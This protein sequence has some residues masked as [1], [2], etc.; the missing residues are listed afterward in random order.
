MGWYFGFLRYGLLVSSRRGYFTYSTVWR[1]L[2][3]MTMSLVFSLLFKLRPQRRDARTAG[4]GRAAAAG[5]RGRAAEGQWKGSGEVPCH[6]ALRDSHMVCSHS[7]FSRSM[8]SQRASPRLSRSQMRRDRL[9]GVEWSAIES[10]DPMSVYPR[11]VIEV[12]TGR[13]RRG[14]H[15]IHLPSLVCMDGDATRK[16]VTPAISLAVPGR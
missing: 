5:Q 6:S 1:V 14:E 13:L 4:G 9:R 7:M 2:P 10:V 3:L 11:S 8:F 15:P 12:S 16:V